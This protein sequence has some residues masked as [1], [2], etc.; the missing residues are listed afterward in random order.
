MIFPTTWDGWLIDEDIFGMAYIQPPVII[1]GVSKNQLFYDMRHYLTCKGLKRKA[2][3]GL[4]M[5]HHAE[6]TTFSLVL[7]VGFY[8]F[9][10]P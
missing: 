7:A 1:G 3:I 6:K 8:D 10:F 5:Y 4:R 2:T 9:Y